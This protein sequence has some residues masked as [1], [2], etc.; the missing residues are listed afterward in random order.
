MSI[1][2]VVK[3]N[4][5]EKAIRQLK[6]KLMREGVVKELKTRQ[7]YEKPSEKK[8]RLKKENIKRVLKNKKLR[9]REQ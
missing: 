5:V 7:Y 1:T 2:V 3:N 8:L 4:N 9:E 6:K